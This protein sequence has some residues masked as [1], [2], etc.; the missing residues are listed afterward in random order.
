MN[1]TVSTPLPE[2]CG[3]CVQR[4]VVADAEDWAQ[5]ALRPEMQEFTSSSP[6]SIA[7]LLPV[8]ERTL[9]DAPD[10]PRLFAVRDP[11]TRELE[12]T[13]GFH[14]VSSLNATAELT[15]QVRPQQWRCGLATSIC[16]A[17]LAWAFRECR[18]VRVQAT[19]LEQNIASIRVLH[20]CGFD[21]EGRLRNFR[22]VR[23]EPRDFLLFAKLPAAD[24]EGKA[25]VS[26]RD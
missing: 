25:A 18:L 2:V 9:S 11:A 21:F 13:F 19:V 24:V 22:K 4:L 10:A 14:T 23:G 17:A 26:D 16:E 3:H 7:D 20:K 5:F 1:L 12:A 6:S 15:Y 8:I